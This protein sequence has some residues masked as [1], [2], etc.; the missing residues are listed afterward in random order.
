MAKLS[1]LIP[2]YNEKETILRLLEKV[3]EVDLGRI[4]KE[5]IIIDDF[6]TDGTRELLQSIKNKYK[7][8]FHDKNYG[9]GR[10]I[11]T[12]LEKVTG[13]WV[14]IQDADLEYNPDD[15]KVLLAK[16]LEPGVSVVYGSRRLNVNLL[17]TK[18]SGLSF[19]IGGIFLTGLTNLLY[20]TKITDEA[21]CYKMFK[22]ELLKSFNLES[23]RFEFCPE[24]TAKT[25]KRKIKIHEVPINYHP[26]HKKEG[27]KINWRD[28][29]EAIWTLI[30]Y[31]FR[32]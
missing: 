5:V 9:K 29:L 16:M 21:V 7:I 10:A 1:I 27:K 28:G 12:G 8:L 4:E 19:A 2:V 13:D 32:K 23:E 14:I 31:K 18:H 11:R 20:K 15:I 17:K 22:T 26:R 25:A 24:V 30:K 3:G 6:S